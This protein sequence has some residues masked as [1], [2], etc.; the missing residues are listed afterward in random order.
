MWELGRAGSLLATV[1]FVTIGGCRSASETRV[2]ELATRLDSLAVTL[3][4]V[5]GRLNAGNAAAVPET[6]TVSGN[7]AAIRGDPAALVTIVEFTDYQC[8]FCG[9][10]ANTTYAELDSAY[11]RTGKVRYVIRDLPLAFHAMARPA[12]IAARCAGQQESEAYWRYHDAVFAAQ[13]GLADSTLERVAR[14]T[15]LDL[16]EFAACRGSAAIAKAVD[17]DAAEAARLQLTGTPAFIIGRTGAV[18]SVRGVT[19]RGAL[20]YASFAATIDEFLRG[21]ELAARR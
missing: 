1:A 10:H 7:G 13:T 12:A 17:A 20:P 16:V 2:E 9:R 4:Q 15:R 19:L 5:T 11:I 14:D 8:P 3:T 21:N 6:L 18:D